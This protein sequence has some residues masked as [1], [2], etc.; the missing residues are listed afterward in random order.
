MNRLAKVDIK[1]FDKAVHSYVKAQQDKKDSEAIFEHEREA[2]TKAADIFYELKGDNESYVLQDEMNGSIT[3]SRVQKVNVQWNISK[4]C[5]AVGKQISKAI[6]HK[7]YE[8]NNMEGLI[9]YLKECGVDPKVFKSYINV[10]ESVD[11]KELERLEELGK[12][13]KEQLTGCYSTKCQKPYYQVRKGR[14]LDGEQ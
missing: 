2:F 7:R 10:E 6:I 8:I 14:K 13:S 9:A 5:K 11:V 12:I 1:R 4:L 3:V